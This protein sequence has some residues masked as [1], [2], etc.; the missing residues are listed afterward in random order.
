[1]P[2]YFGAILIEVGVSF[3]VPRSTRLYRDSEGHGP[4]KTLGE[5]G[6]D[7]YIHVTRVREGARCPVHVAG[8]YGDL[9]WIM[10]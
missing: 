2:I 5:L 6:E 7:G 8:K 1:M 3:T 9:G 4:G 10:I